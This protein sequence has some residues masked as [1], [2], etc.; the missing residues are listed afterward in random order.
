MNMKHVAVPQRAP[1][2]TAE[3]VADAA[4]LA[5]LADETPEGRSIAVLAKEKYGLRGREVAAPHAAAE[6]QHQ[7]D[8][9]RQAPEERPGAHHPEARVER[10]ERHHSSLADGARLDWTRR[11]VAGGVRGS[12]H[13]AHRLRRS[14]SARRTPR[15]QLRCP[16]PV[17]A[18]GEDLDAPSTDDDLAILAIGADEKLA[19]HEEGVRCR[20]ENLQSAKRRALQ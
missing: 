19:K 13:G 4:Q 16:S 10:V 2:M 20:F 3:Q 9:Q 6:H 15:A 1:G 5:S 14:R 11:G 18:R 8:E 17:A 12:A 7:Q